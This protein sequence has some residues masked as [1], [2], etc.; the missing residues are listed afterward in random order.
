MKG[1]NR[2]EFVNDKCLYGSIGSTD[3]VELKLKQALD[4]M[5]RLTIDHVDGDQKPKAV[6]RIA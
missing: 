2:E 5:D 6:L 4:R 3:D 1:G